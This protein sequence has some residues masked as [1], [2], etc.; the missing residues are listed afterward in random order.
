VLGPRA[1]PVVAARSLDR[2]AGRRAAGRFLVEGPQ[3]VREALTAG[4]LLELLATPAAVARHGDLASAA[5][6]LHLVTE[7]ALALVA[8]TR[9]PQGLV[10]TAALPSTTPAAA[11]PAAPRLVTVL[12]G[13][14]DP[15]NLGTLVRV[16]D[17]VGAH[18]VL[19]APGGAAAADPWGAK[20]VR[21]SAGSIFH[22]PVAVAAPGEDLT[23]LL[24]SRGLRIVAADARGHSLHAPGTERDLAA[25]TAWVFGGEAHGVPAGWLDVADAVVAVPLAGRAESLNVA[26]AAAV[27]LYASLR[28]QNAD[29]A[30]IPDR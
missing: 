16:S 19:V 12:A 23:V 21:S 24:H 20:A 28:W 13:V 25:P 6:R 1:A 2:P 26:A 27:C 3:A 11:L 10:G 4:A 18:A 29:R 5:P 15:G 14:T 17:A 8:D 30:G 22:L 9:T 7:A